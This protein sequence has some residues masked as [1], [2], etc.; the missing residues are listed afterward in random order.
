[1]T[2]ELTDIKN[3]STL[4]MCEL[5]IQSD[6]GTVSGNAKFLRKFS[7]GFIT[8]IILFISL[9]EMKKVIPFPA[10]TAPFPFIFLSN[11]LITLEMILLVNP[12]KLF[13]A[14][15]IGTFASAFV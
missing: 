15:Q 11:L 6:K 14:K 12:D 2:A 7:S 8:F 1:M 4:I 13:L 10:L 5:P 3:V 9:F